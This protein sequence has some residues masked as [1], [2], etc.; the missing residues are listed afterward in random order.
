MDMIRRTPVAGPLDHDALAFRL[1]V[2][3]IDRAGARGSLAADGMA[4]ST[5]A[6]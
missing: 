6:T 5:E 4:L 1:E 3:A 2:P